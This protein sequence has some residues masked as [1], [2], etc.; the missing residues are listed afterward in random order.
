MTAGAQN[1]VRLPQSVFSIENFEYTMGKHWLLKSSN[2]LAG[3]IL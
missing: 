3:F 2:V 1:V